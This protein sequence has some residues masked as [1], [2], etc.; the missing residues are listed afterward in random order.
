[1]TESFTGITFFNAPNKYIYETGTISSGEIIL[2]NSVFLAQS[3]GTW[4]TTQV[5]EVL[6]KIQTLRC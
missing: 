2:L 4:S 5:F 3:W 6:P 1:M